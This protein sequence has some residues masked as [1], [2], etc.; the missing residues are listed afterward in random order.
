MTLFELLAADYVPRVLYFSFIPV[1]LLSLFMGFFVYLKSGKNYLGKIYLALNLVF[2]FYVLN[3]LITW[4]SVNSGLMSFAWSNSLFLINLTFCLSLFFFE[5]F[6]DRKKALTLSRFWPT[7]LVLPTWFFLTRNYL[8][9]FNIEYCGS[10][11]KLSILIYDYTVELIIILWIIFRALFE[12]KKNI[13]DVYF[14]LRLK[15]LTIGIIL[16]L[17]IFIFFSAIDSFLVY[18]NQIN[19]Y[20]LEPYG[21]LG[22]YAFFAS[23]TYLMVKYKFFNIKLHEGIALVIGLLIMVSS[24]LLFIKGFDN[25]IFVLIMTV[26][27]IFFGLG[28]IRYIRREESKKRKSLEKINEELLA[29]D[30]SKSEFINIASHQLRTPLTVMKGVLSF[31]RS[32]KIDYLSKEEKNQLLDSVWKKSLK[33]ENIIKNII[34]AAS[35]T[36]SKYLVSKSVSKV[37]DIEKLVLD[38]IEDFKLESREWGIEIVFK[39]EPGIYRVFGV[40][41]D[42]KEAVNN[43]M[44]NAFKYCVKGESSKNKIFIAMFKNNSKIHLT[45]KDSGI[46]IPKEE[47]QKLFQKFYRA[48]NAKSVYTD[49]SGLGLFITKEIIE[50]HGGKIWVESEQGDGAMFVIELPE[51]E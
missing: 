33:M 21:I 39:K 51:I 13:K 27:A 31:I 23:I 10:N 22:V 34:S 44:N 5:S 1:M 14:R 45:I 2:F 46:G 48:T 32:G 12:Y 36:N 17:F 18:T 42:L 37:V 29:L 49:G 41:D 3:D 4:I 11:E 8:E 16:F 50:G 19:E 24:Q 35:L 26:I 7:L 40:E 38:I 25:Q 30:K 43:I 47:I 9:F 28:L 20:K 6:I 15:I